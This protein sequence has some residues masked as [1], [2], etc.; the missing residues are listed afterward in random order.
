MDTVSI[1]L[2]L[3]VVALAWIAQ[4]LDVIASEMRGAKDAL[5]RLVN[6]QIA[7]TID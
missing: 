2:F 7:R 3:V 1:L 4:K 6:D 5:E